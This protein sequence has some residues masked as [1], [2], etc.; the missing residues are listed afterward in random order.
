MEPNCLVNVVPCQ[1]PQHALRGHH[2]GPLLRHDGAYL[3]GELVEVPHQGL[4]LDPAAEEDPVQV[5]RH[6]LVAA[7]ERDPVVQVPP[8]VLLQDGRAREQPIREELRRTCPTVALLRS[9]TH[10]TR[11]R[12]PF[13]NTILIGKPIAIGIG[14]TTSTIDIDIGFISF[15]FVVALPK[16]FEKSFDFQSEIVDVPVAGWALGGEEPEALGDVEVAAVRV[17]NGDQ[18]VAAH[19]AEIGVRRHVPGPER[20]GAGGVHG[21]DLGPH[22]I[23]RVEDAIPRM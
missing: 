10:L 23:Q 9:R 21:V 15:L 5:P 3:L 14:I 8:A 12:M 6:L 1:F 4:A 2:P 7:V 20:R 13:H 22:V 18:V 11:Q 19:A 16:R 17:D